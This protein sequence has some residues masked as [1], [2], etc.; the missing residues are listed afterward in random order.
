MEVKYYHIRDGKQGITLAVK[1]SADVV[2]VGLA[3]C[4]EKDNFNKKV[5]RG[6]ALSRLMNPRAQKNKNY[7]FVIQGSD[8]EKILKDFAKSFAS[9]FSRFDRLSKL[10][11][12]RS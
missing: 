9:G 12:V 8:F 6:I 3:K 7:R 10:N 5:G 4:C 1:E 2:E 11:L